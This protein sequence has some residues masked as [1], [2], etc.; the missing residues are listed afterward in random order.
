MRH[1]FMCIAA[2]PNWP[3]LC[4]WRPKLCVP[5]SGSLGYLS[6][7]C[8]LGGAAIAQDAATDAIIH[9]R[10]ALAPDHPA[11]SLGRPYGFCL[12]AQALA[13]QGRHGEALAALNLGF[14]RIEATGERVWEAELNRVKGLV[15][16]A[17]GQPDEGHALLERA[18]QVARDQQAKS[19]ELRAATSLAR[20]LGERGRRTEALSLLAPIHDWFTE[21]F[22]TAD[23]KQ[24]RALL[25]G[26]A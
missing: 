12:L 11:G 7:G 4:W 13:Q 10:G 22:D 18:I 5:S 1:W 17:Q 25:D 20:L 3:S 15:L 9:L 14:A 6:R 26:L 16:V 23:L 21:G 8:F 24:A 19:L 2:S